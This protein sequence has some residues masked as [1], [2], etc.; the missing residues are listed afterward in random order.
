MNKLNHFQLLKY[1]TKIVLND[2]KKKL[3]FT[4]FGKNDVTS[5]YKVAKAIQFFSKE[6]D[7][8]ICLKI[9]LPLGDVFFSNFLGELRQAEIDYVLLSG[10]EAKET[11]L[12]VGERHLA[13]LFSDTQMLIIKVCDER[14]Y[15]TIVCTLIDFEVRAADS[16][17][18][19]LKL[20]FTKEGLY[21][22]KFEENNKQI[23]DLYNPKI[24]KTSILLET[25]S[26]INNS[27]FALERLFA[28][29]VNSCILGDVQRVPVFFPFKN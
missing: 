3:G 27:T 21:L 4:V 11:G 24:T 28:S 26:A 10:A 19:R 29:S 6:R 14:K 13:D 2:H 12:A 16:T 7:F 5:S 25:L 23:R 20:V 15:R 18:N 1:K 8:L 17:F 22:I 9:L